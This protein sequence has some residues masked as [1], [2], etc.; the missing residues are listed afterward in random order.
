MD[1][2]EASVRRVAIVVVGVVVVAIIVGLVVI[3]V[4]TDRDFTG[5]GRSV[6]IG[7]VLLALLGGA[8]LSWSGLRRKDN[9]DG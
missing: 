6:V 2:Q 9:D 8:V 5:T 1:E 4:S 3:A 7:L